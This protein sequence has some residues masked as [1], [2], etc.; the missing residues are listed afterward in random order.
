MPMTVNPEEITM[1]DEMNINVRKA[2]AVFDLITRS[3]VKTGD[4]WVF[5]QMTANAGFDGYNIS[6]SDQHA[7]LTVNFHNTYRVDCDSHQQLQS[8]AEHLE[9]LY[10]LSQKKSAL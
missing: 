7:T 1:Q 8:F 3:G 10:T 9:R 6:L 4:D 5:D 2:L